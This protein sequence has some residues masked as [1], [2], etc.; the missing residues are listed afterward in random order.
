MTSLAR[1]KFVRSAQTMSTRINSRV[2]DRDPIMAGRHFPELDGIR[3]VA[4]CLVLVYHS[5]SI[6]SP[7]TPL[8]SLYIRLAN[9]GWVGVDLF[10]I[11]SG[12]LI[13][14]ILLDTVTNEGYYRDFYTRRVLLI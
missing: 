4:I 6:A 2:G 12:F 11:L 1:I 13:T 14:A 10:F 9:I 7:Q 3:G 8:A 5:S